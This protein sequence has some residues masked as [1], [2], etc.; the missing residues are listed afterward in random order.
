MGGRGSS[1][2][3]TPPIE[4][5]RLDSDPK[6]ELVV[7]SPTA[8]EMKQTEDPEPSQDLEAVE[9]P[10]EKEPVGE[11]ADVA[12]V[13]TP[14]DLDTPEESSTSKETDVEAEQ[15]TVVAPDE[16]SDEPPTPELEQPEADDE[17]IVV[18]SVEDV[19]DIA[20]ILKDDVPSEEPIEVASVEPVIPEIAPIE[21]PKFR[22]ARHLFVAV[23]G[24]SL[25][26]SARR[27][28][29][30]L[31]PGGVVLTGANIKDKEQ[32]IELVRQIKEAVGL[33]MGI[34]DLPLIAVDQEGGLVNRLRLSNA[35][36]AAELGNAGDA[37]VVRMT[38]SKY[39]EA[40]VERG[41]GVI[42]APVMDVW[43][44]SSEDRVAQTRS[45]GSDRGTVTEMG[46]SFAT[47]AMEGGVLPVAKHFPGHGATKQDSHKDLAVL[48]KDVRELAG[49]MFPFHEAA[50]NNIPGMMVGHIAVPALEKDGELK[51][52]S[53]SPVMIQGLLRERWGYDGVVITDDI[54]MRS[55]RKT[56]T[57][58]QA[59]VD[60]LKAGCDAMIVLYPSPSALRSAC[61]AIAK[62]VDDGDL[63][64]EQVL[65]SARRLDGWQSWLREH[66]EGESA[67][68]ADST[69][70]VI[71][72]DEEPQKA[73]VDETKEE[74][75]AETAEETDDIIRI[76]YT[77]QRGDVLS[78]IAQEYGVSEADI[79]EWNGI[80]N[81]DIKYG[82]RLFIRKPVSAFDIEDYT[83]KNG[84]SATRIASRHSV[85]LDDFLKLNELER[86]V[87]LEPGQVVKVPVLRDS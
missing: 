15:D 3:N 56:H 48:D 74:D 49:V 33:G 67:V 41:I 34:A 82:F 71:E 6:Q 50:M 2:V 55:I 4:T 32:T 62:A 47:G 42:I 75:A 43:E 8:P 27:F 73:S 84:E 17:I 63:P 39:A 83:V 46:L 16:S 45:Y 26:D 66:H 20:E 35:P 31:K 86:P 72:P 80:S 58:E 59:A 60:A 24:Q 70:N 12:V 1:D 65:E 68:V 38:A 77:I 7:V 79:I 10:P 61:D 13:E 53:L 54:A 5:A 78:R 36:S 23:Q 64:L 87:M 30:E 9:L 52:A 81:S 44:P 37:A 19:P 21:L 22:P 14:D 28:L 51:P 40:C 76:V 85:P 29:S 11:E 25:T 57:I 18:A 69:P